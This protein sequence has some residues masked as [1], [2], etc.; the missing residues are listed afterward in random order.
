MTFVA[1]CNPHRSC[2]P[3][4]NVE[5]NKDDWSLGFYFV[6]PLHRTVEFLKWDYGALDSESERQYIRAMLDMKISLAKGQENDHI[7][8][9]VS[10]KTF[11]DAPRRAMP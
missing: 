7:L 5:A 6:K 10:C 8:A 1:A 2:S 11:K 3:P 9:T 4:I